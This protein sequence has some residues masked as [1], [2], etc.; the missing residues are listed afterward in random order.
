MDED[1]TY[2][3]LTPA[4]DLAKLAFSDIYDTSNAGRQNGTADGNSALRHITVAPEQVYN[5]DVLRLRL[6]TDRQVSKQAYNSDGETSESLTEPDSDT[7]RHHRELGMIWI[8][9]YRMQLRSPPFVPERGWT[10]GKGPLEKIP[11]HGI[12]LRNPHVRFNFST[13]HKGL[14]ITGCS[15][16]SLARVTVNGKSAAQGPYYLNKHRM[17]IGLDKLEYDFQWTDFSATEKFVEERM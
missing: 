8:G 2:A 17:K 13:E 16:S 6:E 4:N 11:W 15:R 3:T 14:Y 9:H 1:R 10:G 5:A 7:E 12:N